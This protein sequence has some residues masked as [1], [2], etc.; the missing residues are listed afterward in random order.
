MSGSQKY[1]SKQLKLI[2]TL[3][4]PVVI[5]SFTKLFHYYT[6][7]VRKINIEI[8]SADHKLLDTIINNH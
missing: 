2:P 6:L 8:D 3:L 5:Y 4:I 1:A 7:N